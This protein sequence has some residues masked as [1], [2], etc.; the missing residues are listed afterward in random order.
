MAEL[1][2]LVRQL[3]NAWPPAAWKDVT[4]LVA[5]SGGADSVGLACALASLKRAAD[6]SGRLVLGHVNHGLRAAESQRDEAFVQTLGKQ[7]NLACQTRR[8]AS[9]QSEGPWHGEGPEATARRIRYELLQ[10]I[11]ETVGAR[12]AATAHTADDQAETV[13]HRVIRGTGITGLA[14]IPRTRRLGPAVTLIRPL[15]AVRRAD[16][17]EYLATL[18]QPYRHDESNRDTRFTRNRI[19]QDLIPRLESAYNA[20]V[21]DALGRLGRLAADA[22]DVIDRVV[23]DLVSGAVSTTPAGAVLLDR[24][25]LASVPRYLVREVIKAAWTSRAWPCQAMGFAE[26][27]RL[28]ATLLRDAGAEVRPQTMPG[29]VRVEVAEPGIVLQPPNPAGHQDAG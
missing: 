19:R 8:V 29:G 17:V 4:V 14:G 9:A 27:E 3:A 15:L 6:G 21:V 10:D 11:A 20:Q 7:L 28:A 12:Y 2:R 24:K 1:H 5:V 26:W 22:Q 13:L 23:G 25:R 16:L 18:D